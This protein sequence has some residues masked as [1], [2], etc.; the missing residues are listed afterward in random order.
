MLKWLDIHM[1]KK[2]KNLGLELILNTKID[3]KWITDL[4][5]KHK[6]ITSLEGNIGE[7]LDN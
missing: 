7:N 2:K 1:P 5:V 3:S 6:T 4:N